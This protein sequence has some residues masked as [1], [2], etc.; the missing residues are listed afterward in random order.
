MVKRTTF[1]VERTESTFG[2]QEEDQEDMQELKETQKPEISQA[3]SVPDIVNHGYSYEF[4]EGHH[5]SPASKDADGDEEDDAIYHDANS[6]AAEFQAKT[7]LSGPTYV[8]LKTNEKIP[9]IH[10]LG[11]TYNPVIDFDL[12]RQYEQSLF[13]FTYR[14]DFPEIVPYKIT[15]D[16]GWGCMLRSAQMMLAHALRLHFQSR[17]W[18]P[19]VSVIQRRQ[20]PFFSSI[21]TWFAD[22][23]SK[24]ESIYSLHNMVAAGLAK[25]EILPGEWYG[26]GSACHVMRDLVALHEK[27]QQSLFRVYVATEGTVYRDALQRLMCKDY[28]QKVQEQKKESQAAQMISPLHP[29]D[30]QLP[31]PVDDAKLLQQLQWDTGLLLLIPLRLGL[32]NFNED[33]IE[34]FSASFALPQSVGVLGGRPRGARWF[35]GAFAD[36]SKVLGLDPHT[37]QTAPHRQNK[38][39]GGSVNLSDEYI[40]SVHTAYPEAYPIAKMDPSIALGFYCRDKADFESLQKHFEDLK[41]ATKGSGVPDMFTFAHKAPNY[42]SGAMD[43]MLLMDSGVLGE[44]GNLNGPNRSYDH[45]SDEDEYVML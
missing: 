37:V 40:R 30:P 18:R 3:N 16:A 36:G 2:G 35:Y 17:H 23:P 7:I 44:S 32:N 28:E 11:K 26:P 33:Y 45:E 27:R 8:Q 19:P 39:P 5:Q 29:L 25:Y 12:R 38:T 4:S 10:L 31:A 1:L 24:T 14:C 13:W 15:T 20:D 6:L 9:Y 43:D 41:E 22:F 34:S 21:L 42:M